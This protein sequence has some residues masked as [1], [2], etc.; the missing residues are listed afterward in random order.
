[1]KYISMLVVCVGAVAVG[2]CAKK[3]ADHS[4][5]AVTESSQLNMQANTVV[6]HS[7]SEEIVF[8]RGSAILG[9]STLAVITRA[10]ENGV[11]S[12][13]ILVPSRE[14]R[15][16][17]RTLALVRTLRAQ[18]I[19][20]GRIAADISHELP[21]DTYRLDFSLLAVTPPECPDWTASATRTPGNLPF[22]NLGCA[23]VSNLGQ[24]VADPQDLLQGRGNVRPDAERTSAVIQEY[25]AGSS[26]SASSTDSSSS[27]S[28]GADSGGAGTSSGKGE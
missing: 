26:A 19:E 5:P 25:R 13:R 6:P 15:G 16:G 22:S 7:M 20:S 24:M 2:G 9:A 12:V 18:G 23:T 14:G 27:G 8:P 4:F 17:D 10:S 21:A 28:S 1:M 3:I 11:Q